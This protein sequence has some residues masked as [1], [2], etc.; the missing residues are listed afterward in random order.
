MKKKKSVI[1]II[2]IIIIVIFFLFIYPSGEPVNVSKTTKGEISEYVDQRS[3]TSLPHIY[4][5]TMPFNARI[6][7][8]TLLPGSSV[9]QNQIIAKLV[10]DN[11]LT[12]LNKAKANVEAIEAQIKIIE[13]NNMEKTAYKESIDWIKAI[14]AIVGVAERRVKASKNI[15]KYAINYRNTQ[16]LSGLGVST[17]VKSQAE[18]EAAVK[19]L[20]VESAILTKNSLEILA[21]IF[22][23]APIYINEYLA[24]K[25]LEKS[26]LLSQLTE[27]NADLGKAKRHINMSKLVSPINGTILRR[28]ITNE[29][30]LTAGTNIIDI[31]NLN[32]LEITSDVLSTDA[33]RI[34]INDSVDIHGYAIGNDSIKGKVIRIEPEA[35]TKI[36]SLGVEEQRVNVKI[37]INKNE[38]V[39]LKKENKTLG[40]KYRI[41]AR[42]Y[43]AT[44]KNTLIIPRTALLKNNKGEWQVF[45]IKDNAAELTNVTIG[46]INDNQVEILKGL[47]ESDLVVLAPPTSLKDATKVTYTIK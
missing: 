20:D 39:K 9:K 34:N 30:F 18:M 43:T 40:F 33:P 23:L 36:S 28:Y 32:N 12:N 5:I 15:Y 29:R 3:I 37:S 4:H 2:F 19:Q 6:H 24:R 31:G 10:E 47:K 26:V 35:F 41:Y 8:V 1:L 44:N 17:I 22:K 14:N 42:I 27:A 16:I 13:Y 11:L 46:L 45:A 7:A 25:N 38:L 21:T